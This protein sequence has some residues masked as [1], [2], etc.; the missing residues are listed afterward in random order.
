MQWQNSSPDLVYISNDFEFGLSVLYL[1][2]TSVPTHL[3]YRTVTL[4]ARFHLHLRAAVH[5]TSSAFQST[6]LR[7][8]FAAADITQVPLQTLG[9]NQ[10]GH[11]DIVIPQLDFQSDRTVS[12][13]GNRGADL[14]IKQKGSSK[15]EDT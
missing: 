15:W 4:A 13:T 5:A 6:D 10:T 1:S 9:S 2:A 11:D 12:T 14:E 3:E 7:V 8:D